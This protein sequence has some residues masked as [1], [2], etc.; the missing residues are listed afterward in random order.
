M[1]TLFRAVA[2]IPLGA[3][4]VGCGHK[5]PPPRPPAVV[6]ARPLQRRISEW[7]DYVGR[8]VAANTVEVRPRVSGYVQSV[9]FRDGQIVRRGQLL[10]TIDPRA[11][12]AALAQ[13]KGQEGR[14]IAA[15]QDAQV[16][17][18]RARALLAARATSQQEV[19]T[20]TATE[21]QAEA[22]LAA[23]RA[24]VAT[25][26]LN[27]TFTR[28]TAPI[29]GRVSDARATPGNL[30]N[31]D[32]TVLTTVVSL[33]P[34]RF[35]FEGPESLF[36]KYQRLRPGGGG[37]A[38][39]QIRLQDESDYRW[40]GRVAFVDNALD[41]GS[42]T[43]RAYAVVANP[44]LFLTPGMFGHMRLQASQPADVLLVPDQAT[45]TDLTRQV[46]Y[47]AGPGGVVAQ[48]VV[49]LGALVDGLRVVRAGL[50]PTDRVIISGVQRAHPGQKVSV[51][52]GR[53]APQ[54]GAPGASPD[55]SPPPGT[56]TF[57]Q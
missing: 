48:R 6:V 23:A 31:Q 57:A 41:T 52:V 24:A 53:I 43:I 49:E 28:V 19:D 54:P 34:I 30:V 25:A 46:V 40:S 38:P 3:L 20:R 22:D 35:G 18:T 2:L 42:G 36:L 37:D 16:E 33:D 11:Y 5:P 47:V 26:Q 51:A 15:L 8:F 9:G 14:A 27:V 44:R 32:S 39:V 21:K 7:D 17:L 12:D 45:V 13:A 55:L 10:F 1:R 56:A 29:A 50:E 4:V